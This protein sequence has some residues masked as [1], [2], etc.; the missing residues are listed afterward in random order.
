MDVFSF[1]VVTAGQNCTIPLKANYA[2]Q[3]FSPEVGIENF[4]HFYNAE[5]EINLK[6][7]FQ[8]FTNADF[9]IE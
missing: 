1:Q 6:E 4:E 5:L 2:L 3:I 7:G 9:A 8:Y